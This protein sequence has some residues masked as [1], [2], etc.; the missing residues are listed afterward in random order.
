MNVDTTVLIALS[1]RSTSDLALTAATDSEPDAAAD[2][3]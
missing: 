3:T 2:G 1:V